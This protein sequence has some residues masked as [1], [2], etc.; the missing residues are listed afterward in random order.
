MRDLHYVGKQRDE[1]KNVG[2]TEIQKQF[3]KFVFITLDCRLYMKNHATRFF[4]KKR[5]PTFTSSLI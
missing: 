5:I 1:I 2:F 3:V 4:R